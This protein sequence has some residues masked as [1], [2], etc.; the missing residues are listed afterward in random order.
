MDIKTWE[1]N[2]SITIEIDYDKCNGNGAC[3]EVCPSEVFELQEGKSAAVN[4]DE[5]IECC[6]CVESCP[7][8]AI[9]HSSC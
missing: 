7:Q 9:E 5:C 4:V 3:V 2:T 1:S 6:A 8:D